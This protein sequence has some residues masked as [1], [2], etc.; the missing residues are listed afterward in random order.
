VSEG[1]V[2]EWKK[3]GVGKQKGKGRETTITNRKLQKKKTSVLPT[4]KG[5]VID[6][7]KKKKRKGNY[8]IP[9][10][11]EKGVEPAFCL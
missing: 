11:Q 1:R 7:E 8:K 4:S 5:K 2:L 10:L 6:L 9:L 3:G